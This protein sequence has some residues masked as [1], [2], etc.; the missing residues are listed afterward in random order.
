MTYKMRW[1]GVLDIAL[2][3]VHMTSQ[4]SIYQSSFFKVRCP[5]QT[6]A[7]QTS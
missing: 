1:M 6:K 4:L 2:F 5:I 3:G 7:D